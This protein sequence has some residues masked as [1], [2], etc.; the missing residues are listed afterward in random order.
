MI[1]TPIIGMENIN[2]PLRMTKLQIQDEEK[3][4]GRQAI[5]E[6]GETLGKKDTSPSSEL[7]Q[8]EKKGVKGLC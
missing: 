3:N 2:T 5:Q 6:L 7:S 8:S 1:I 4:N